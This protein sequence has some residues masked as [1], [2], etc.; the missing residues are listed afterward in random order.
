ML[1]I[2]LDMLH[3][4]VAKRNNRLL[5]EHRDMFV[6][7]PLPTVLLEML[8]S[9]LAGF[10]SADNHP[11]CNSALAQDDHDAQGQRW[12]MFSF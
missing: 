12:R 1:Q 7:N 8:I 2:I 3:E 10:H 11:L 5:A 9:T 6:S 4:N